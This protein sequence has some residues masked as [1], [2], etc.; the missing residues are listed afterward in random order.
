MGQCALWSCLGLSVRPCVSL[1]QTASLLSAGQHSS[2]LGGGEARPFP[3]QGNSEHTAI[4]SAHIP[5]TGCKGAWGMQ[6]SL[7]AVL[8]SAENWDFWEG[9]DD[10]LRAGNLC[11]RET[12]VK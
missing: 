12:N 1:L 2:Q 3:L 5:L 11:P 6:T 4:T 8:C 9:M 7:G 10:Y